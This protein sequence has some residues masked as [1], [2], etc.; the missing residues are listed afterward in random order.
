MTMTDPNVQCHVRHI[1][2]ASM[3]MSGAREWFKSHDWSWP[4]FLVHGRP[5]GDFIATGDPLALRM[6]EAAVKESQRG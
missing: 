6:V 1:R 3:C 2:Q 4:D 5:S